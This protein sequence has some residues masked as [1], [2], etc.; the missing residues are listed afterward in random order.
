MEYVIGAVQK[1]NSCRLIL[2]VKDVKHSNFDGR[3]TLEQRL[4]NTIVRDVFTVLE[5]YQTA[6]TSDGYA[7]DWYYI[8]DHYRFEDRS[9]EIMAEAERQIT[10]LEIESIEQDLAITDNEIAIMELQE[11]I[12]SFT[13]ED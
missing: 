10:D 9:D 2:K 3:V 6:D 8:A 5:K 1:R 13:Q 11:I 12:E 7:Y 4:G